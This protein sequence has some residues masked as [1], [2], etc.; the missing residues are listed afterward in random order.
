MV[1]RH[2]SAIYRLVV[3]GEQQSF[4]VHS[5]EAGDVSF[6]I[7]PLG[8]GV[9]EVTEQGRRRLVRY[10]VDGDA[11]HV[12]D[13]GRVLSFRQERHEAAMGEVEGG[14]DDLK[15]PT[16][17]QVTRIFVEAGESVEAGQPLY[18]LEAMKM[19]TLVRAPEAG[20]VTKVL[21][22]AGTQVDV[23]EQVVIFTPHSEES[24]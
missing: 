10:A 11:V 21:V 2:G 22:E 5:D 3:T 13:G 12:Q 9:L 8:D 7:F 20:V 24:A 19:E 15:A 4:V 1:L 14:N 6:S 17:G 16:P 23:G 18:G